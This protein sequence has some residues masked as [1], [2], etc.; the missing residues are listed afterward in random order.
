[1]IAGTLLLRVLRSRNGVR[2]ISAVP[3][4]ACR[5]RRLQLARHGRFVR[6]ELQ[7]LPQMLLLKLAFSGYRTQPA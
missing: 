3:D 7:L 4:P 5:P 6:A 1:M 2:V